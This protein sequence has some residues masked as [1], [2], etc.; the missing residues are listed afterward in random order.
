MTI[1]QKP[2][3]N[4]FV[5]TSAPLTW[6]KRWH[7]FKITL[8]IWVFIFSCITEMSVIGAWFSGRL[9]WDYVM[10]VTVSVPVFLAMFWGL[11]ELQVWFHHRSKRILRVEE[12]RLVVSSAKRQFIRWKSVVKIQAEPAAENPALTKIS[13]FTYFSK[14]M[15]EARN[16][17]IVVEDAV[18]VRELLQLLDVKR[19]ASGVDFK[20]VVL[21]QPA[22]PRV[23]VSLSAFPLTVF[24]AGFYCLMHGLPLL[25]IALLPHKPDWQNI[26]DRNPEQVAKLGHFMA[27]HFSSVAQLHNF[28]LMTGLLLTVA[29]IALMF[30]RLRLPDSQ[31][32]V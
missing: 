15:P 11:I 30:W 1:E 3:L 31:P 8:P 26:F 18:K 5:D 20:I 7:G 24:F 23:A 17:V 25:G 27:K 32:S 28:Y 9:S 13:V 22:P 10:S 19:Q 14:R 12:K 6:A 16:F 21:N 2:E 29:G 4:R